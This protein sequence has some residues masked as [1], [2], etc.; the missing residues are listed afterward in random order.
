MADVDV[1]VGGLVLVVLLRA[2]HEVEVGVG[3]VGGGGF[4]FPLFPPFLLVGLSLEWLLPRTSRCPRYQ[5][6]YYRNIMRLST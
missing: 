4:C 1:D 3:R 6:H 5:C 2:G